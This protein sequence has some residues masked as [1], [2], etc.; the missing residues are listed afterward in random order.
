MIFIMGVVS[1]IDSKR[2]LVIHS[3]AGELT[4]SDIKVAAVKLYDNPDFRAD[5]GILVDL[6]DG[7]A[8]D[9]SND[10]IQEFIMMTRAMDEKRGTGRTAFLAERDVDY[11]I[12]RIFKSLLDDT[13]RRIGVFRDHQQAI[14]WLQGKD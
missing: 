1:T 8:K 13:S 5:M 12:S 10:D 7:T 6:R 11:G 4:L 14:D 9:L 3:V 2:N